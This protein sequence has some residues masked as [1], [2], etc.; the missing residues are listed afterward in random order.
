MKKRPA[1]IRIA[2]AGDHALSRQTLR[3]VLEGQAGF[4]L[5]G[6]A[7]D[8]QEAVKLAR[9]LKPDILLL[10]L[11]ISRLTGLKAF[12]ELAQATPSLRIILLADTIEKHQVA[13]ALH[14]GAHG[15]VLKESASEVLL[16]C[17]RTVA[18]GQYWVG[19]EGVGDLVHYIRRLSP[20][21]EDQGTAAYG[22]TFRELEI[23]EAVVDGLTNKQIAEKLSVSPDSV[24]RQLTKIL[25]KLDVANRLELVLF[26]VQKRLT[27]NL[28]EGGRAVAK[29]GATD[30]HR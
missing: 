11:A 30:E 17:I 16:K 5:V 29:N 6:E 7:R 10:D 2:I 27:E 26:A 13:E 18:A 15:V 12:R 28:H 24:K 14:L 1:A 3:H 19:R 23:V 9:R 25:Q 8:G 22:L 4:R 21:H 20:E